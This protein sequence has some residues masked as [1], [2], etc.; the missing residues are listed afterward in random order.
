MAHS[1]SSLHIIPFHSTTSTKEDFVAFLD[2]VAN[3]LHHTIHIGVVLV[4]RQIS[5]IVS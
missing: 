4:Q 3:S 2:V 1:F 5:Y